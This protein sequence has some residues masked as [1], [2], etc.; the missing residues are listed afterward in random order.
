MIC[1]KIYNQKFP[2]EYK[3]FDVD[4]INCKKDTYWYDPVEFYRKVYIYTRFIQPLNYEF[5]KLQINLS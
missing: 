1:F 5:S 2:W 4:D 3:N